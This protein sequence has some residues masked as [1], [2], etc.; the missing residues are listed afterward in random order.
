MESNTQI[1][2]ERAAQY[3]REAVQIIRQGAYSQVIFAALDGS[4]EQ[5]F[6]GPF[7]RAFN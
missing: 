7:Q 1:P 2:R 4:R 3:G 5:R 6:I